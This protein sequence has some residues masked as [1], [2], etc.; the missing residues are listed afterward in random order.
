ML[1]M[2]I[3]DVFIIDSSTKSLSCQRFNKIF[4]CEKLPIE[5]STMFY[6]LLLELVMCALYLS[7]NVTEKTSFLLNWKFRFVHS[8]RKVYG[9]KKEKCKFHFIIWRQYPGYFCF[10]ENEIISSKSKVSLSCRKL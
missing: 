10:F 4:V 8:I 1:R 9:I 2:F 6:S 5:T 7:M 3:V